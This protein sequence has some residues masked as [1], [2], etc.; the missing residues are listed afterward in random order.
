MKR[1]VLV[2]AAL[3]A[4]AACASNPEPEPAP[5]PPPAA[6]QPSQPVTVTPP[7]STAFD[8]VGTY[9]FVAEF[10]GEQH[11]G[12]LVLAR[13]EGKLIGR[14]VAD[15][16][17]MPVGALTLEGK[18]LSFPAKMGDGIDLFFKLN[19]EDNDKFAGTIDVVGMGEAKVTG[20]RKKG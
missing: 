3:L 1:P 18:R 12:T 10:Q 7:A 8:P 9:T 6:V 20:T 2:P 11:P 19:F 16:G 17:E 15:G 13:S 5:T 14:L 4:L